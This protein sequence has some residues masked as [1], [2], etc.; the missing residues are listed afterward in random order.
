MSTNEVTP[1]SSRKDDHIHI[2]LDQ[3][4]SSSLTTGLE[5]FHF[6]HQALPELDLDRVDL[7]QTLFHRHLQAPIL[8]S[9]M[10]GGTEEAARINRVLATVAQATGVAMGL[11]SQ[12]AALETPELAPT[13][14]VRRYAPDI[15][16]FANL[17]AVQLNYAYTVDHCKQAVDMV[18]ADG[19]ILH[20]NALQEAIQPE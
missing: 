8:I 9:S 3:D 20:L 5:H 14:Q 13:F 19:L 7:S 1:T 12:R 11:G 18:E 10:T 15:L 4:V 16:L 17:G 2:N 6:V